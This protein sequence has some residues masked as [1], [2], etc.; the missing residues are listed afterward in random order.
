M[1]PESGTTMGDREGTPSFLS[2]SRRTMRC[3]LKQMNSCATAPSE[4]FPT[5]ADHSPLLTS[6][7]LG[8]GSMMR[9]H[10]SVHKLEQ[11]M[12]V[13][14]VLSR[15]HLRYLHSPLVRLSLLGISWRLWGFLSFCWA[16]VVCFVEFYGTVLNAR[17]FLLYNYLDC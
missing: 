17:E 10:F 2:P 6:L 8:F 3:C 16:L 1:P 7:S 5:M 11:F 14:L 9:S 12:R 13:R 4:H 15:L